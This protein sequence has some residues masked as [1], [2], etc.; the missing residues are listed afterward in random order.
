MAFVRSLLLLL[1]LGSFVLSF[2]RNGVLS[3][4]ATVERERLR[5]TVDAFLDFLGVAPGAREER[6]W[7]ARRHVLNTIESGVRRSTGVALAMAE[8]LVEAD[9]TEVSGFPAGEE[10]RHYE[11]LVAR[12]GPAREAV[13]SHVPAA[14]VL[15]R[16][17][18]H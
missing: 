2:D 6:L 16:L 17:P 1:F 8:V 4:E 11:D 5:A 7:N 9:P 18:P 14:Q 12:Y 10:L 3:S 13:A 15:T